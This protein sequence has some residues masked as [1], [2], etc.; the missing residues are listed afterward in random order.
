MFAVGIL[1]KKLTHQYLCHVLFGVLAFCSAFMVL[2]CS[3]RFNDLPAFSPIPMRDYANHSVGRFKSTYIVDQIDSYYRGVEP[4]PI[5]V[6]T[7]VNID[8]LYTSST[9]GRMFSEQIMSELAMRGYEVIE[10]RHSDAVQFLAAGGEFALSRQ[11][12]AVR[13][14]R[15][16]GGVIVGTYV[17]SPVR[18]YV[19]VRLLDPT[20]SRIL[21]AGSVEMEKTHELSQLLRRGGS[22]STLERIPVKRLGFTD[23]P[24][25]GSAGLRRSYEMEELVGH[26]MEGRAPLLPLKEEKTKMKKK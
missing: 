23:Q 24:L 11:S 8:D 16:L 6:T 26:S 20:T 25:F 7:L 2:G 18:L 10:L 4:G 14:M 15:E 13:D 21:S 22:I 17:V 5:G 1:H 9:F 3:K 12:E 19:N